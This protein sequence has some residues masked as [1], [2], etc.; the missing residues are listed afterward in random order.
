MRLADGGS[1]ARSRYGSSMTAS[2]S[3]RPVAIVCPRYAPA[4]GGVERYVE[5]LAL[6]LMARGVPVEIVATDPGSRRPSMEMRGGI[7]VR[8]FPTLAGDAIYYVSPQLTHWL[9]HRAGRYSLLHAHNLHTLVPLAASW[10][11]GRANIPLVLTA[12]YHG[13]GHTPFRNVLHVPYRPLARRVVRAAAR[14]VCN[15]NAEY[16]L[17][18]RDFGADIRSIVIPE[19]IDPPWALD[20][21][22]PGEAGG[23]F[24][25][26]DRDPDGAADRVSI[27]SVGRLETYKGVEHIVAA[28]PFLPA[29]H[30]LVVVGSGPARERI[31]R[32][33]AR[34]GVSG[35]VLLC[36]RVPDDELRAWYARAAVAVSLSGHESFGLTVLESAAA[37]APV[38]ASDIPAHRES[39]AY[40][41]PG[42]ISL[43]ALRADGETVAHAITAARD[44]GRWNDRSGW[45]LPTWDT[46]VDGTLTTYESL[47]TTPRV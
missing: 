41:P 35:R 47:L 45:R 6:G 38:V 24:A 29:D 34:L 11:A 18:R 25:I 1:T 4:V 37:G 19:G 30:R 27:L 26:P 46:L 16:Q 36:G 17:L 44:Q 23:A 7:T 15:S 3:A 33:A 39:V 8:R 22:P 40:A 20:E 43:V 10:G 9:R 32:T 42:R 12:H 13:T 28:L 2:W 5:Q 14:V 21:P 31:E